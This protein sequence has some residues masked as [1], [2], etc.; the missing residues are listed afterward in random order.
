VFNSLQEVEDFA[1]CLMK[2]FKI[3]RK[4]N[5]IFSKQLKNYIGQ[6]TWG[7]KNEKSRITLSMI[8]IVAN[9]NNRAY[10]NDAIRHEIAHA[11]DYLKRGFTCHDDKWRQ[12]AY[13]IGSDGQLKSKDFFKRKLT[14]SKKKLQEELDKL[15]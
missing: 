10:I 3:H 4:V 2:E 13:S 6:F 11:M 15:R 7:V 9:L 5:L 1:M 12:I 8:L 14:V